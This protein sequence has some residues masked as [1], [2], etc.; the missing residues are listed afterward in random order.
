[1]YVWHHSSTAKSLVHEIQLIMILSGLELE[2]GYWMRNHEWDRS[3]GDRTILWKKSPKMWP[4]ACFVKI[5][6][7]PFCEK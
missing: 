5:N 1:M 3:Q 7:E 6:T 2:T 4:K